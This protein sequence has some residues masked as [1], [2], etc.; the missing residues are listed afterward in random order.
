[1]TKINQL[2]SKVMKAA[3]TIYRKGD[4][5]TW[6]KAMIKAWKWAKKQQAAVVDMDGVFVD[7]ETA[8][9]VAYKVLITCPHT[10][11]ERIAMAWVP[12]SM[13][14]DNTIPSWLAEKKLA[15][16]AEFAG[17]G[18]GAKLSASFVR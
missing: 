5:K 1:M 4:A 11:R 14:V 13:I 2:R 7:R 15:E 8:K 16:A 17:A 18:Y 12:K 6:S 3:W 9:A 10:G